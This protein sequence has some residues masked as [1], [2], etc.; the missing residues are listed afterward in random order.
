MK[1]L[2]YHMMSE[3]RSPV[4]SRQVDALT[5]LEKEWPEQQIKK[6]THFLNQVDDAAALTLCPVL[7]QATEPVL[8]SVLGAFACRTDPYLQK[9]AIKT[10]AAVPGSIRVE[11]LAALITNESPAL[12]KAA[13]ELYGSAEHDGKKQPLLDVLT[14]TAPEVLMAALDAIRHL[15]FREATDS[16]KVL[17]TQTNNEDVILHALD[18]LATIPNPAS[19]PTQQVID[20]LFAGKSKTIGCAAAHALS[21]LQTTLH[22]E[23]LLNMLAREKAPLSIRSAAAEALAKFNELRVI[24]ALLTTCTHSHD[25]ALVL[26][27]RQ[28]LRSADP[29]TVIRIAE[30]VF[31]EKV[32]ELCVETACLLTDL[33]LP[34][35]TAMLKRHFAMEGDPAVRAALLEAYTVSSGGEDTNL[36]LSAMRDEPTVAYTAIFALGNHLNEQILPAFINEL[37]QLNKDACWEAALSSL[38][39][40]AR[41]NRLPNTLRPLLI[42]LFNAPHRHVCWLAADL[43]GWM[44]THEIAPD[45]VT[46]LENKAFDNNMRTVLARSIMRLYQNDL[47]SLVESL[48]PDHLIP[49]AYIIEQEVEL[50]RNSLQLIRRL[51]EC[52]AK[53]IPGSQEAL[54][55]AAELD[56]AEFAA[57][58]ENVE[59]ECTPFMLRVWVNLNEQQK[60]KAPLKWD[61]WL[62]SPDPRMRRAALLFLDRSNGTPFL[63]NLVDIAISDSAIELRK[64]A[65]IALRKVT[66]ATGPKTLDS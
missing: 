44:S 9:T 62:T 21:A 47:L 56:P 51:S 8:I 23:A 40:Y 33:A 7:A 57:C 49:L 25:T 37:Y 15:R 22:S 66:G 48:Q 43:A 30:K 11:A 13:C 41:S 29:D 63:N 58:T 14:D 10:L 24:E 1:E 59:P 3:L 2:F 36:L 50:G 60:E 6:F 45:L 20:Y 35:S 19:F 27:C 53:G 28:S 32:P 16:L 4:N 31:T 34:K 52:C 18:T 39:H 38:I 12:R 26:S 42:Q 5:T 54:S 17:L 65:K 61:R 64:L 55:A 46:A